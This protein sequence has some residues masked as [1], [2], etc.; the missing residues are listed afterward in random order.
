[1]S[2]NIRVDGDID[3]MQ[4]DDYWDIFKSV[5]E[6]SRFLTRRPD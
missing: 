6:A 4:M 1:M 5:E 2:L 3:D